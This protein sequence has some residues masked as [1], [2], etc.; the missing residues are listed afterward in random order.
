MHSSKLIVC[1]ENIAT[2]LKECVCR[3]LILGFVSM[4]PRVVLDPGRSALVKG[5][6]VAALGHGA[7][8]SENV[9]FSGL[10][11]DRLRL[12]V[13]IMVALSWTVCGGHTSL[14]LRRDC[15]C[16]RDVLNPNVVLVIDGGQRARRMS[17]R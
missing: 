7:C 9:R 8:S 12:C 17:E 15:M 13:Q 10:G 16:T 11:H 2:L 14:R 4:S 3:M 5:L 6:D 1:I